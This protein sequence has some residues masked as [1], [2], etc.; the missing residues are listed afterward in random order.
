MTVARV[1]A[2]RVQAIRVFAQA[3][4]SATTIGMIYASALDQPVF[5]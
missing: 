3:G 5:P 1:G 4:S 2:R